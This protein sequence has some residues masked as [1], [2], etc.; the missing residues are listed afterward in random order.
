VS[1]LPVLVARVVALAVATAPSPSPS[2]GSAVEASFFDELARHAYE[3]HDYV[4]A[5]ASFLLVSDVSPS[6]GSLYNVAVAAELAGK[7]DVA[8]A[9]YREYLASA[10]TDPERRAAAEKR[11][12]EL[13]G[14]LALVQVSS[15]PPGAAIYVDREE[16]GAYGLTPRTLALSPGEHRILF[17]VDGHEPAETTV[18]TSVGATATATAVLAP[19]LGELVVATEPPGAEIELF[20]GPERVTAA[21]AHGHY[22][23]PVGNYRVRIQP[24]GCV[25][26]ESRVL[27]SEEATSSA[28]LVA[29][30]LPQPT[31]KL[32]ISTGNVVASVRV[33][34]KP[35]ALTPAVLARVPAGAH[36]VEVSARGFSPFLRRVLVRAGRSTYLEV[37][38]TAGAERKP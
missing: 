37:A 2:R 11:L 9:Y 25:A 29:A 19:R 15:E 20:R 27:V 28:T 7:A 18:T 35:V 17:E 21:G 26:T 23:L 10:D 1:V 14:V 31:G 36:D 16:L 12:L 34:G 3:K 38:L 24:P 13:C 4:E 33:D 5:L 32:L 8:Y 6:A 30:P 22:R